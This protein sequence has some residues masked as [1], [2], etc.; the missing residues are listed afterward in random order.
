MIGLTK[1]IGGEGFV[2]EL[3][4]ACDYG[5]GEWAGVAIHVGVTWL[6]FSMVANTPLY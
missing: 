2:M 6:A 5:E 1:A 4:G 3:G